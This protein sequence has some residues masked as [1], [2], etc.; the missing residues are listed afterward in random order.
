MT[1]K[2]LSIALIA[3]VFGIGLLLGRGWL[4][5][6]SSLPPP[7]GEE[8]AGPAENREILYWVAP[9]DPD[10]R[11]DGP[12]KSPMGMDL[13]PVYAEGVATGGVSIDPTVR[14]NLGVRTA[15]AERGPLPRVIDTVGY[16]TWDEETIQ[17]VHTRVDGWIESL[18]VTANGDP[19]R[20]GQQ[21]F[22]LYSPALVSAQQEY[23]A[24]N[25]GGNA[26]LRNASRE[27]LVALGM[28]A[29]SIERLERERTA[30]QRVTFNAERDGVIAHLGVREGI[31]VTPST[32]VLSVASLD[33][34][35]VIAE[36][37]E[38]QADWVEAGQPARLRLDHRPGEFLDAVVDYVYPELDPVSRTLRVR[39]RLDN[40]DRSLRPNMFADVRIEGRGAASIVHIPRQAVIRSGTGA[41]V[42]V[43]GDDGR[44]STREVLVGIESGDRV[45]IRRGLD[46]GERVVVSGQFLIDAEA[47]TR[48]ALERVAPGAQTGVD[49]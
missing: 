32:E 40:Q 38:R 13:V 26:A 45:A 15:I 10:Y 2:W 44:F 17:H 1:R 19:V 46:A 4:A 24:A 9:M 49:R 20:A 30:T 42:V 29:Q 25:A 12:G 23:L 37:L 43:A 18:A 3:T 14:A 39:L 36:V 22:E 21:L 27:R 28:D 16:V 47:S 48:S 7:A 34:V 11:R 33:T 6:P 8:T 35:W 31:F 41:R 5:A